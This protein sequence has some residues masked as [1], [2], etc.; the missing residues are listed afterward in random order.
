MIWLPM[1]PM[2]HLTLERFSV[3]YADIGSA[4]QLLEKGKANQLVHIAS[5]AGVGS[6]T[7]WRELPSVVIR[8]PAPESEL[9]GLVN[10]I[11]RVVALPYT[12]AH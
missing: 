6:H 7:E 4:K 10:R 2:P 12:A 11:G 9:R 3:V 5:I 1:T 8:R